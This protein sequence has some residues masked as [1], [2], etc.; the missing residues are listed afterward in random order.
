MIRLYG[1]AILTAALLLI[2]SACADTTPYTG[3][4]Y[5]PVAIP[6]A[7][8]VDYRLMLLGDAGDDDLG[9]DA[10]QPVLRRLERELARSPIRTTVVFLGDIV[11]EHGYPADGDPSTREQAQRRLS[12]Q[13]R[14]TRTADAIFVPGNHDWDA[15]KEHGWDNVRELGRVVDQYARESGE[16]ARVLPAGGCPGPVGVPLGR[17]LLL[18]VLDTQW[19]LHQHAKPSE[20][21]NPTGCAQWTESAVLSELRNLLLEARRDNRQVVLASHHPM[22]SHGPHGGFFD[23]RA[24]IFPITMYARWAWLPLP[25]I[26]S[27]VTFWRSHQSW[28][29]Q[30]FSNPAYA[31]LRQSFAAALNDAALQGL[32]PLAHAAGHEHSLQV[33]QDEK[34]DVFTLVSGLGSAHQIMHVTHDDDT[35]FS[36]SNANR[37]GLMELRFLTD[38]RGHLSVLE[39]DPAGSG[40]EAVFT[41][42]LQRDR[43]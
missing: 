23:W 6:H 18:V 35:L 11:Y 33:L 2:F 30:D 38:G 21:D 32:A 9:T 12:S 10:S 42:W 17:R 8:D 7:A 16:R 3:P 27:I 39:A 1:R 4:S 25:G 26:G 22:R 15:G 14:A 43:S 24:Q 13:L 20:D 28:M 31:H 29:H 41:T 36:H 34:S 40:F 5:R 19:W 37:P